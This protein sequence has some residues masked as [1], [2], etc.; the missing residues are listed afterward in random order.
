MQSE[1]LYVTRSFKFWVGVTEYLGIPECRRNKRSTWW[2][3]RALRTTTEEMVCLFIFGLSDYQL[4]AFFGV[5][6][7]VLNSSRKEFTDLLWMKHI[8]FVATR[9]CAVRGKEENLGRVS[10]FSKKLIKHG[11]LYSI[12]LFGEKI[13]WFREGWVCEKSIHSS[14]WIRK[15]W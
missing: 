11:V 15:D 12:D 4:K 3:L 6:S 7:F 13:R 14:N 9:T 8:P 1:S 10:I 5:Q 2:Q